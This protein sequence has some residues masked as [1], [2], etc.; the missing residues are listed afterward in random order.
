MALGKEAPNPREI[1]RS[2]MPIVGGGCFQKDKRRRP[3]ASKAPGSTGKSLRHKENSNCTEKLG[4]LGVHDGRGATSGDL[5][6]S[7]VGNYLIR[8]RLMCLSHGL[9]FG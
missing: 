9:N 3:E 4:S 1:L 2:R 5:V 8:Q 7:W 6:V